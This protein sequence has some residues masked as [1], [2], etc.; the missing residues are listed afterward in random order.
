MYINTN[1]TEIIGSETDP[2]KVDALFDAA[3]VEVSETLKEWRRKQHRM[4]AEL[5]VIFGEM[6]FC[7]ERLRQERH[8]TL[9]SSREKSTQL[10]SALDE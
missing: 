4:A 5:A 6:N 9:G 8:E 10:P 2:E 7:L 1:W 3:Y